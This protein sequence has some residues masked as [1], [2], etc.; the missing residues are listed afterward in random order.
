MKGMERST[1]EQVG[2]VLS[3]EDSDVGLF[4]NVL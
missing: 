3:C 2:E 4:L 1:K